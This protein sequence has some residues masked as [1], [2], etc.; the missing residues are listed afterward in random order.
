MKMQ[1]GMIDFIEPDDKGRFK[2]EY[3]EITDQEVKVLT[4]QIK[5]VA[6]EIRNLEFWERYCE[7]EECEYCELRRLA[8]NE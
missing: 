2:S 5:F 3:F 1:G 8:F 6:G 4:D 7:D